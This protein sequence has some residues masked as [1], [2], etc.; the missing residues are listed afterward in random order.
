MSAP[1]HS[2][3]TECLL[4]HGDDPGND[5]QT[6]PPLS[7]HLFV[8]DVPTWHECDRPDSEIDCVHWLWYR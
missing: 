5:C 8:S 6:M 7:G 2:R 4:P 1:K 3:R